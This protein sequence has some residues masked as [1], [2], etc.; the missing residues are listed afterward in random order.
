M[1]EINNI[2]KYFS[3]NALFKNYSQKF[4]HDKT[5]LSAPNGIGKTTLLCMIAGVDIAFSGQ[6][7]LQN[8]EVKKR[9]SCVA[10]ASDNIP[11]PSFLPAKELL[12]LTSTAWQ[13]DFPT[14]LIHDFQFDPFLNT[15]YE[16]LSSGNKKKLQLINAL[17]RNT[18]YL[19]LDEPTA[20]L[21]AAGCEYIV[22]VVS[23]YEGMV[24]MTSHEPEPFLQVGFHCVPLIPKPSN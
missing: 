20:A 11:Y 24:L 7:L 4:T 12:N 17:M 3:K 6:I 10:L 9:Q 21:D 14:E 16:D 1:I 23:N 13:C 18:P 22:E 5:C 19:L 2:D 15:R 8:K